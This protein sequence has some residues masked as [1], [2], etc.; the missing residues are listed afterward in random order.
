MNGLVVFPTFFN[1][2]LNLAI[3]SAWS[4]S[5]SVQESLAEAWVSGGLL[6]AGDTESSSACMRPFE[7]GHHY[8]HYLHHTLASD[9]M[10]ER[11]HSPILQQKLD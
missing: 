1:L 11:E 9:Q 10:I 8:L 7:G 2:S 6:R 3:R 4:E 5:V